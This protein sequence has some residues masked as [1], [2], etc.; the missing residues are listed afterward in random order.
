MAN[1]RPPPQP[2]SIVVGVESL[3]L[4]NV[5]WSEPGAALA[6]L[7]HTAGAILYLGGIIAYIS[8]SRA[9][10]RGD[11][12]PNVLALGASLAYLGIAANLLGGF[13]RTYQPGH[14]GIASFGSSSWVTVMVFKHLALFAGM[15]FAVYLFEMVAPRLRKA[16]KDGS[17]EPTDRR[18]RVP[19]AL[20]V[21]SILA[22]SVLGA[23]T[24]VL[25]VGADVTGSDGAMGDGD[26]GDE[27][28]TLF[29][30]RTYAASG[31]S[32][33]DPTGSPVTGS[34]DVEDGATTVEAYLYSRSQALVASPY[35][36][37][38]SIVAPDGTTW[39]AV[40]DPTGHDVM[41]GEINGDVQIT[42]Q[43]PSPGTWQ[44]RVAADAGVQASWELTV[45]V[46]G[47]EGVHLIDTVSI[48]PGDFYEIN[49]VMEEGADMRWEWN[50]EN[51]TEI[52][53]NVHIHTAAGVDYPVQGEWSSHS[54][55]YIADEDGGVSIMWE[56]PSGGSAVVSYH[57][58]GN[59]TVHSIFD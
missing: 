29:E 49:T 43:D 1:P 42:V 8:W 58:W 26:A 44:Y 21:A 27:P 35:V 48:A 14:P 23:V 3:L 2:S 50:E 18:G 37:N 41:G 6:T 56:A 33:T 10:R 12:H 31:S 19:A 45:S 24:T 47:P 7:L 25:D 32:T 40:T 28:G 11:H 51:G 55:T 46:I 52:P 17:L 30:T 36:Y 4:A 16:W 20:V 59:F 9:I 13:I 34:F 22:A 57:V 38:L 5:I 39:N 53:F 15:V 54:G